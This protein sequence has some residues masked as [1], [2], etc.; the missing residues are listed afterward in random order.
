MHRLCNVRRLLLLATTLV[1]AGC[2]QTSAGARLDDTAR[3]VASWGAASRF[4]TERW[5][6]RAVPTPYAIDALGQAEDDVRDDMSALAK[7]HGVDPIARDRASAAAAQIV[8]L[9]AQLQQQIAESD[10]AAVARTSARLE[11]AERTLRV[12]AAREARPR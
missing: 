1:V 5:Q 7:L 10:G 2:G 6:Q 4:V 9:A 12:V 3:D 8:S 11:A